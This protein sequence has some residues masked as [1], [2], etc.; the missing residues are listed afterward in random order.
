MPY[1]LAPPTFKWE[2]KRYHYSTEIANKFNEYFVG[3]GS[4]LSSQ[5]SRSE[6]DFMNFMKEPNVNSFMLYPT[7]CFEIMTIGHE[8]LGKKRMGKKVRGLMN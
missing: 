7:Y 2:G 8:L 4:S 1:N 3:I 6:V 5:L